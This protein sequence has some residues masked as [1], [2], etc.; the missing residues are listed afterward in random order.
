MSIFRLT[1]LAL[2]DLKSI[3]R[4]TQKTWGQTQRQLYL[5]KLDTGF[6]LLA[7][8]PN[9]GKE[10][11]HIRKGYRKYPLGRHVIFY[12]ITIDGIE[13]IRILHDSMDLEAHF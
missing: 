5:S 11:D 12:R 2:D 13:I 4:Y 8:E 7:K 10:C 9:L 3:G 1:T 6:H